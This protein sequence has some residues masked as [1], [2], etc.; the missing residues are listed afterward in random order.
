MRDFWQEPVLELQAEADALN[1]ELNGDRVS[2]VINRNVNFTNVCTVG[3]KFCGF[4]VASTDSRAY[5]LEAADVVAKV[6]QT[7]WVTEVCLQGGIPRQLTF[8]YYLQLVEAIHAAF[9]E[10]HIHAFSPMEIFH[11]HQVSGQGYEDI[12]RQLKDRGLS[13]IPGTAAEILVDEVREVVSGN[14]LTSDQWEAIVR[15]AHRAGIPSTATMMFGHIET[16]KHIELHLERLRNI[17]LDTGGFTEF[18]PLAFIPYDNRLGRQLA[19]SNDDMTFTKLDERTMNLAERIY[20]MSRLYFQEWI[21]NLQTSW[22]KLGRET[23]VES[24]AW[25]CN[26]FG[27]T[28]YEESITKSSGGAHGE[29]LHPEE[30]TELVAQTGK[31]AI[32]RN[33]LYSR[34]GQNQPVAV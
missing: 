30:I 4:G 1:H 20:P 23:A 21:P 32:Q 9:P 31:T 13:S 28:L 34:L 25:G 18:V 5:F 12:L 19:R 2:Y 24:L 6:A 29:V 11:M 26:D 15:T 14:K 27:G 17:Q 3:C 22:V 10:I 7:P 8:E 16:E 33:T